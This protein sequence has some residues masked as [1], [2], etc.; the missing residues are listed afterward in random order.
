MPR[1][2]PA[3]IDGWDRSGKWMG[4]GSPSAF[5][6]RAVAART[7]KISCSGRWGPADAEPIVSIAV[8]RHPA[9]PG[10]FTRTAIGW[11]PA[12]QTGLSPCGPSRG[13]PSP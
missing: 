7:G 11:P 1:F 2:L 13:G 6:F 8:M 5:R 9:D 4:V 12:D 3:P 10:V